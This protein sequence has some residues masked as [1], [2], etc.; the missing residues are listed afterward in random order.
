MCVQGDLR[1]REGDR[2]DEGS[3]LGREREREI[4]ISFPEYIIYILTEF[5]RDIKAVA[6]ED[7]ITHTQMQGNFP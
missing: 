3:Y 7:H 1:V 6:K 4:Y 5:S 2:Y